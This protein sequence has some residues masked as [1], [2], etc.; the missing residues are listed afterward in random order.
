MSSTELRDK[1][2]SEH[3]IQLRG[4]QGASVFSRALEGVQGG[5]EVARRA[6]D[7]AAGRLVRRGGAGERFDLLQEMLAAA[8]G[9]RGERTTYHG[10]KQSIL[11]SL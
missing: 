11:K 2:R 6:R 4:I 10:E 9:L 1:G 5:I 7:I 8:T 3:A